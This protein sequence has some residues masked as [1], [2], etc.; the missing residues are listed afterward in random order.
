MCVCYLGDGRAAS[1]G[2]GGRGPG[3]VMMPG[4]APASDVPSS[5]CC[6]CSPVTCCFSGS[7]WAHRCCAHLLTIFARIQRAQ[8]SWLNPQ[9]RKWSF[10]RLPPTPPRK[11]ET[12]SNKQET[13]VPSSSSLWLLLLL[14]FIMWE[15]GFWKSW[16][17]SCVHFPVLIGL[18]MSNIPLLAI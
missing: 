7:C 4:Y 1:P 5:C 14:I 15:I 2:R 10:M 9:R 6:H 11:P 8:G 17:T 3:E 12:Y 13:R 18:Y 16:P